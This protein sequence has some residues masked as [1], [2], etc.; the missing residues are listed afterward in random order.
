[1][2]RRTPGASAQSSFG[3]ACFGT[4]ALRKIGTRIRRTFR[5]KA[6]IYK[7]RTT[8]Q[9]KRC[10]SIAL[11]IALNSFYDKAVTAPANTGKHWCP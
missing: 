9:L 11:A 10:S 6:C 4:S 3:A 5:W 8:S 2:P 1:M 7:I